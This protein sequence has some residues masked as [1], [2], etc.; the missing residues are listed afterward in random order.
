MCVYA[1]LYKYSYSVCIIEYGSTLYRDGAKKK[2]NGGLY[3][4]MANMFV[5]THAG[6]YLDV[7][8]LPNCVYGANLRCS[9]ALTAVPSF[10]KWQTCAGV[11]S[12]LFFFLLSS[13]GLA[14]QHNKL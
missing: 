10:P 7:K 2:K 8:N 5:R 4:H 3:K 11:K 9:V 14:L 12:Q 13:A 1:S 6:A